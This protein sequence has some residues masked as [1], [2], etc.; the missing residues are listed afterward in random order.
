MEDIRLAGEA[1]RL[2]QG[3]NLKPTS[4]LRNLR[5]KATLFLGQT[6]GRVVPINSSVQLS[7]IQS[8]ADKVNRPHAVAES[9]ETGNQ[10]VLLFD[11]K[12]TP[13]P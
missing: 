6:V 9:E 7:R 8:A 10:Y 3:L 1:L 13:N 11:T 4:Y 2:Q 12:D 5:E